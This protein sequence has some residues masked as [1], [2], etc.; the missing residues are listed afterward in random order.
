MNG[1]VRQ[2][3]GEVTHVMLAILALLTIG[4]VGIVLNDVSLQ[5]ESITGLTVEENEAFSFETPVMKIAPFVFG[6]LIFLILGVASVLERK[7]EQRIKEIE[8]YVANAR[9]I[10]FSDDEITY[11]LREAGW[12]QKV[13]HETLRKGSV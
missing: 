4:V 11:R 10:G 1:M 5:Q 7:Q 6:L 9:S 3:R 12:D 8:Q 2:K 13:I